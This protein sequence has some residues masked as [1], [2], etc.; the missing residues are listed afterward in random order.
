MKGK[1][2]RL[3][4]NE[5]KLG[6]IS[7]LFEVGGWVVLL[8]LWL[9]IIFHYG[10][11]PQDVPTHFATDGTADRFS[12]KENIFL[13]PA[14]VTILYGLMT[15]IN[16]QPHLYRY[17]VTITPLNYKRNYRRAMRNVRILKFMLVILFCFIFYQAIQ[18]A[19][20]NSDGL[21][22]WLLPV[23]FIV[24]IFFTLIILLGSVR[25]IH[26]HHES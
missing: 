13:L 20:G 16:S 21:G 9:Y 19:L 23:T 3:T 11:L 4:K 26:P 17:L 1:R 2:P 7:G 12:S 5:K 8:V 24:F 14:I 22:R 25:Y 15:I 18:V 6:L 10:D